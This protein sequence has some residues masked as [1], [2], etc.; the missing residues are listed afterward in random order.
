MKKRGILNRDLSSLLARIGHGDVLAIVD[1]GFPVPENVQCV[2]LS[3]TIGKPSIF[4]VL[5]PIIEELEIEKVILASEIKDVS[6]RYHQKLLEHLPENV[7]IEYVPHHEAFKKII[8]E[9]SKGIVRTGEK[10][11]YSSVILIGGVTYHGD[12]T[13]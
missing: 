7:E 11:S 3:I 5:D 2:D 10:V 6:P 4:E 8:N 1:S 9:Q 13:W 12:M